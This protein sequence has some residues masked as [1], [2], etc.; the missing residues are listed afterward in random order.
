MVRTRGLGRALG[1][2]RG[3]ETTQDVPKA[4]VPWHCRPTASAR[5]QRV[6]VPEDVAQRP[7]DVPQLHEDAPHVSDG[8][9]D[10]T[11]AAD[12]VDTE[13]V[14][15]EVSLGSPTADE[16]FPGGPR[17]PLVLTGYAE[18]VAHNIW[19]GQVRTV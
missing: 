19:S 10:M 14:A 18:H 15:T 3:R 7:E 4:D 8:T 5:R 11:S 1:T 2:G 13:G 9:P 17:N 16:G 12:A 6:R